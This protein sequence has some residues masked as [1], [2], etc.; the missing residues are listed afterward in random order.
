MYL[1]DSA[2]LA[3]LWIHDGCVCL[4]IVTQIVLY[5]IVSE[6][7]EHRVFLFPSHL[8][9]T[10]PASYLVNKGFLF[11]K[12]TVMPLK[13]LC[14]CTMRTVLLIHDAGIRVACDGNT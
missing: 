8:R 2:F 1:Q 6:R 4:F 12:Y 11:C 10:F 13:V 7:R 14:R 3:A 9:N 5:C